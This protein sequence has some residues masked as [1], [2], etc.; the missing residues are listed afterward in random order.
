MHVTVIGAGTLGRVYG[1]R[2]ALS[3]AD[4]AFVV[5]PPRLGETFPFVIEQITGHRGPEVLDAPHR[6]AA[7]PQHTSAVLITVRFDQLDEALA[8]LLRAAPPVPL[9]TL[10][11]LLPAQRASLEASVGR[12]VVPA[13]AGVAGYLDE[14]DVVRYWVLGVQSTLIED[15]DT[16]ARRAQRDDLARRLDQAGLPARL[17]RDVGTMNAA[18]T[19]S[20]FPLIAAIDVAGAI[21]RALA[22]RELVDQVLEATKETEKLA[23]KVGK[24]ATGAA[25]LMRFVGPFT[26]KAGVGLARRISPEAVEFV[27]RHFGPKLH[28]QH[29][30]M[31]LAVLELGKTHGVE[32]PALA[33]LLDRL[34]RRTLP[35]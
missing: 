10:T 13:M 24:L 4:V 33:A 22:D 6:T 2:L 1:T 29:R 31:G 9:V 20:F 12:E 23:R 17:E 16:P 14:R 7:V 26:L 21:D 15:A 8:A 27:E 32:M 11:P 25:L 5:R 35:S 34:A 19:L 28:D 18:T 30:A 3:G